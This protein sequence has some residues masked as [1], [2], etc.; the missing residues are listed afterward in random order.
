M[1]NKY[2][3][4]LDAINRREYTKENLTAVYGS[5]CFVRKNERPLFMLYGW[6][7]ACKALEAAGVRIPLSA[8]RTLWHGET[9]KFN[10]I[11]IH[12]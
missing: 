12:F 1:K 5:T 4:A 9:A 2:A 6:R 10:G 7:N 11:E 3:K 8:C